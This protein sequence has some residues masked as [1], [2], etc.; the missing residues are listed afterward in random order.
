MAVA[1]DTDLR[2]VDADTRLTEPVDLWTARI[3][4]RFRARH[5]GSSCTNQSHVA[6]AD[7]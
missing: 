2:V 3:P 1:T 5:A 6:V 7:R 4:E